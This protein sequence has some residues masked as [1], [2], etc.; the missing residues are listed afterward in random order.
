MKDETL[1][2]RMRAVEEAIKFFKKITSLLEKEMEYR[3][4]QRQFSQYYI[5][6][7]D[8]VLSKTIGELLNSERR[9]INSERAGK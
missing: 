3:E 1:D 5:G 2:E 9:K 4:S 8:A 7:E 6:K